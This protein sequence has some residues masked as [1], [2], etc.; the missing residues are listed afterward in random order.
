MRT[1]SQRV[2]QLASQAGA[3][4]CAGSRAFPTRRANR[5]AEGSAACS[6]AD[7]ARCCCPRRTTEPQ[8]GPILRLSLAG[9]SDN[10]WALQ[11]GTPS[12][13]SFFQKT[14]VLGASSGGTVGGL[15][16]LGPFLPDEFYSLF[17]LFVAGSDRPREAQKWQKKN[18]DEAQTLRKCL[19]QRKNDK[20]KLISLTSQNVKN[21]RL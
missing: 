8:T 16:G 12:E 3:S 11:G 7:R 4:L 19:G 20:E 1:P 21:N 9:T 10:F 13:G 17:F 5:G 18:D 14:C 6:A 15:R 2:R